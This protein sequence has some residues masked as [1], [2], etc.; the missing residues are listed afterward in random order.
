MASSSGSAA[1]AITARHIGNPDDSNVATYEILKNYVVRIPFIHSNNYITESSNAF[2]NSALQT[3]T[4]ARL[5]QQI[6]TSYS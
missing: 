3:I 6:L 4:Q 1:Y 5:S 2:R